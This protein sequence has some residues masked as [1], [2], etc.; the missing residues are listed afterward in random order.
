LALICFSA[1]F[2]FGSIFRYSFKRYPEWME[3]IQLSDNEK[4]YPKWDLNKA[5]K[6]ELVSIPYIGEYTAKK[7]ISYRKT[8]GPFRDIESLKS[9]P[10]IREENYAIFSKYLKI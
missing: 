7:I 5:T 4:L 10:G 6:E 8:Q 9:V 2:L 3:I 1:V